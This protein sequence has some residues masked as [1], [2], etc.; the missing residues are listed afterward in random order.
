MAYFGARTLDVLESEPERLSEV[1]GIGA[2]RA[3]M[4]AQSFAEHNGMRGTLMFLQEYAGLETKME[5]QVIPMYNS[6]LSFLL[7]LWLSTTF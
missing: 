6:C 4:I 2:K 3:A 1:P 5:R 7:V